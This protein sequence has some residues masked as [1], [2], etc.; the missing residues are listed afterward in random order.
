MRCFDIGQA[1]ILVI[2]FFFIRHIRPPLFIQELLYVRTMP[3]FAL[4]SDI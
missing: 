1:A 3:F 2:I 4:I